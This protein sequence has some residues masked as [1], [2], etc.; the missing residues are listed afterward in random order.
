MVDEEFD[1][2]EHARQATLNAFKYRRATKKFDPD[3][4]ISKTDFDTILEAAQ[5]TPTSNGLEPF[6]LLVLQSPGLRAKL[7]AEAGGG[8]QW[9]D[10]SHVIVITTK[11]GSELRKGSAFLRHMKLDVQ[12]FAEKD[13]PK[14]E[15]NFQGFLK[16]KLGITDDVLLGEWA[17]RQAYI[18]LG[19]MM[20]AAALIGIDSCALEGFN[21][22]EA[23]YVLTEAGVL[24]PDTDAIAVAVAFGFRYEEP[25]RARTR[26]PLD[27]I[28]KYA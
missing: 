24:N 12:G 5:L 23:T 2:H 4:I 20:T 19:N 17:K 10:A 18:V 14:W 7:V 16:D 11:Q 26:R 6:N 13:F 15:K 27:E 1:V 25:S 28:V 8:P 22:A 21:Y 9:V 3:R